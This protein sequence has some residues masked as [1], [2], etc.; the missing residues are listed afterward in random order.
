MMTTR[1][2]KKAKMIGGP[3]WYGDEEMAV[4]VDGGP[5]RVFGQYWHDGYG[6]WQI[7]VHVSY[8]RAWRLIRER[9]GWFTGWARFPRCCIE[10]AQTRNEHAARQKVEEFSG[11]RMR[12]PEECGL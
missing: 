12:T 3:L 6:K 5:D 9:Q 11:V 7:S 1:L 4:L 2:L 10:L 8:W